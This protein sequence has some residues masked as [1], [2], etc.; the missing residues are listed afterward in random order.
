MNIGIQD[1][2]H[3]GALLADVLAGRADAS[4]LDEYEAERR[5]VAERVVAQTDRLT[6]VVTL[7]GS[8]RR[9]LRNWAIEVVGHLPGVRQTLARQFAELDD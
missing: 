8:L 3:L 5:P 9:E 7:K 4:A 2:C 6:R 1:A